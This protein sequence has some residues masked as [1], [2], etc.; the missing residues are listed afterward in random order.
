MATGLAAE[1]VSNGDATVRHDL[2]G[3]RR[4]RRAHRASPTARAVHRDADRAESTRWRQI[5]ELYDQ[6]LTFVPTAVVQL[7]R[8]VALAEVEGPTP[9]LE[10]VE[11]LN[12]AGYYL[13]H[14][15]RA[16]LLRRAGRNDEARGEY[17]DALR[18]SASGTERDFLI[19]RVKE[20]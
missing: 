7:N 4:C 3:R 14:A 2:T 20:L 11:H 9:A 12:L 15:T 19:R 10:L 16:D 6:L 13:F 18:H 8:C 5:V 17:L 1:P